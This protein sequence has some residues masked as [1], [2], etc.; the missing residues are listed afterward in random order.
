MRNAF[1]CLCVR[2][3]VGIDQ[4][5]VLFDADAGCSMLDAGITGMFRVCDGFCVHPFASLQAST[6][7]MMTQLHQNSSRIFIFFRKTFDTPQSSHPH[8]LKLAKVLPSV[9]ARNHDFG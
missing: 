4:G 7:L 5:V 9:R 8:P 2:V 6:P 3:G 1:C